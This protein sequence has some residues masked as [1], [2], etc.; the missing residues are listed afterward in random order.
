MKI[1]LI[2]SSHTSA[3]LGPHSLSINVPQG[4]GAAVQLCDPTEENA[5]KYYLKNLVENRLVP[6]YKPDFFSHSDLSTITAQY[7]DIK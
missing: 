1:F 5:T 6:L 4:L 7:Q 3:V 2:S